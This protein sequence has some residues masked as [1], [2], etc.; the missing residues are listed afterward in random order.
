MPDIAPEQ[1]EREFDRFFGRLGYQRV[2]DDL[3]NSPS[4]QNADYVH[5]GERI[6]VELKVLAKEHFE[7]G[8]VIHPLGAFVV[9]PVR[10]DTQGAGL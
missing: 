1:T 6:L 5:K 4:F 10:I 7:D 8:G 2:S 3:S 9:Q